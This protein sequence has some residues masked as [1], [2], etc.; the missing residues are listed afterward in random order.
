MATARKLAVIVWHML[1]KEQDY[2]W[3]RPALFQWKLRHLELAAGH[4]SQHGGKRKG[5][6][7]ASSD[8]AVR[9]SERETIGNAEEVYR[10]FIAAWKQQ[11]P[12][13][14]PGAANEVRQT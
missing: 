10:R 9:D 2:T 14:C 5:L 12:H 4:P 8:K 6:A 13:R 1:M 3:S 7:A 11:P